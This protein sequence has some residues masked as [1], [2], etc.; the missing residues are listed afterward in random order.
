M[1]FFLLP[2]LLVISMLYFLAIIIKLCNKKY[3][4][5]PFPGISVVRPQE[6]RAHPLKATNKLLNLAS[7]MC[8]E[9]PYW[10]SQDSVAAALQHP[11]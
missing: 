2:S 10:T 9:P 6:R 4:A 8:N 7:S 1:F 5:V 11:R 3:A